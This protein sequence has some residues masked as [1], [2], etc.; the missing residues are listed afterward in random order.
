[1]G[2]YIFRTP[3]LLEELHR[4]ASDEQTTHDFGRDIL[5]TSHKRMSV[6]A[7][8]FTSHLCPGETEDG[9]GYWRDVGDLDAYFEANMDV[10]S[11]SPKLNFYNEGWPIRGLLPSLGPAKFTFNDS[12]DGRVGMATDSVVGAGAI[13]SGGRINRT[14]AFHGVRVHSRA[15]VQESVLLPQVDVGR[16]ARLRRCIVDKGV[17]IPTGEVIGED[18][19]RDRS[20]FAVSPGG[21]VV[22]TREHYG[23]LDEFDPPPND[24]DRG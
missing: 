18:P 5:S 19:E 12:G 23:Q 11:V 7:Y 20:R 3:A 4:D 24:Q 8:D 21:V 6:F 1:M 15:D 9:R 22:V 13:L 2:N 10:V 14:V 16:E 17:R